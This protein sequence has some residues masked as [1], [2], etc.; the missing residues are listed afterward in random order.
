MISPWHHLRRF[1]PMLSWSGEYNIDKAISDLVAGITVGLTLIPQSIAYASLAGLEPQ[2]GLYSSLCGGLIYA[3][4]GTIPELSIAP[5]ALLSLLTYSYTKN[6]SFGNLQGA[7]LL[8]FL[9]GCIELLC[10]ILHLGFLVDFVSSPVVSAFTSASAITIASTQVKGLLGLKFEAENF[11]SIW[12]NIFKHIS[13][14]KVWDAVLGLFC[15]AIL[16]LMRKLKDYGSPLVEDKDQKRQP[17]GRKVIFLLSVS[18]NALVV[19]GC[20]VLAFILNLHDLKPFSLQDKIATGWPNVSIPKFSVEQNNKTITFID[21]VTELE[22][23]IIFIPFIAIVANIGIAK[24]FAHGKV[25]DATQEMIAVGLCGIVGSMFCS[26]PVNAS[27]SRG[28]VGSA[29][30]IRTPLAG[31]Y[32]AIMVFL[33]FTLLTP[34]FPFIPKPTLAAVIICAVIFMVE[35]MIIRKL[36]RINKLDLFPF[37]ITFFTSLLIGIEVGILVGLMADILK[38]LYTSSRPRILVEKIDV[39]SLERHVKVAFGSAMPFYSAEYIRE[40]VLKE[41]EMK[42][43]NC[44]NVVIELGG[45]DAMEYTTALCICELIKDLNKNQKQVFLLNP[46]KNLSVTLKYINGNG[47]RIINSI[48]EL[49]SFTGDTSEDPHTCSFSMAIRD[50]ESGEDAGKTN[51]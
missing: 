4:F 48:G 8:C 40:T 46:R 51:L 31:V 21:M 44:R 19:V 16:L 33:A 26:Y 10:G 24:S 13:K 17:L 18:K 3:V 20:A 27:F 49:G 43:K 2:Y 30:G 9:A 6:L 1:V 41:V 35:L 36:W 28:A 34:Y 37:F 45:I 47:L 42:G 5:T 32:T 25:V 50:E 7:I 39:N 23:G 12:M 22:T 38:V 15:C 11:F 14:Y 29:S